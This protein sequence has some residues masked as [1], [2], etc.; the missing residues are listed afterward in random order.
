[1]SVAAVVLGAGRG[2]RLRASRSRAPRNGGPSPGRGDDDSLPKVLL[3]LAGRS[4]LAR[5]LAAM[6]AVPAIDLLQ[7]VLSQD[8]IDRW[9]S[10]LAECADLAGLAVPVLGAPVLG[11]P[12]L[13][14]AERVDSVRCGLAALPAEVEWVAVHDAARPLVRT[15]DVEKVIAAA[16][17]SGAALLAT[18]VTDTVHRIVDGQIAETPERATL[19]AAA[20]PQVFR[21]SWLAEA[22]TAAAADG[23]VGTDDAALVVRQGHPVEVVLGDPANV[24]ITTDADRLA[25]ESWLAAHGEPG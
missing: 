7:P 1:M 5:S 19:F 12:V 15:S 14:G 18:P 13:G 16:L 23:I 2:E 25:A 10:V 8:G 9:P 17:A 24:K 4:L 3:P 21:R 22:L 20:T 6:A 11:A